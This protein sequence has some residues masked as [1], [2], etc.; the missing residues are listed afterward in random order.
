MKKY[1]VALFGM[2]VLAACNSQGADVEAE[3]PE[4]VTA[5]GVLE[6]AEEAHENL[7]SLEVSFTNTDS[8]GMV[9]E[10]VAS[11]DFAN[12]VTHIEEDGGTILYKDTDDFMHITDFDYSLNENEPENKLDS[13]V[14]EHRNPLAF[15]KQYD[16]D[17]Y[18]KFDL[19]E[20]DGAYKLVYNGE[21]A[22]QE[23]LIE[24]FAQPFFEYAS[25]I[26]SE[27]VEN[28]KL[29]DVEIH[30]FD[31]SFDIDEETSRILSYQYTAEYDVRIQSL[32]QE[33]EDEASYLLAA[34]NEVAAI[35]KP[36]KDLT[37]VGTLTYDQ[38]EQYEQEA[39]DYIEALIQAGVYQNVDEFVE[40]MPVEEDEDRKKE[41]GEEYKEAF[42]D[43]FQAGIALGFEELELSDELIDSYTEAW[44]SLLKS[45]NYLIIDASASSEDTFYVEVSIEGLDM[46]AVERELELL[47]T[48]ELMNGGYSEDVTE[49]EM[50]SA[51]VDVINQISE[52]D[53][54]APAREVTL[55]VN[56]A[57]G[58]YLILDQESLHS[59]FIQ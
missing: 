32:E 37:A 10:G 46:F 2:G 53:N 31:L 6:Q 22:D 14:E 7:E 42:R 34:F 5:A 38:Q 1:L 43:D 26:L 36:D 12:N 47:L 13:Q 8:Y 51:I 24:G 21:K 48:D 4:E 58:G 50:M 28:L 18:D 52:S 57:G 25:Y 39:S 19:E 40:R 29:D 35:E 59:G 49:E 3:E 15:Y 23:L 16:E 41:M 17:L 30:T 9:Q 56:R 20:N 27:E 11:Y 55:E 54:L 44:L 45:T 33:Y